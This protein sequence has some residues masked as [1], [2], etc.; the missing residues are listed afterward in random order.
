MKFMEFG[1]SN[2]VPLTA[3][4]V[5][6]LIGLTC[7]SIPILFKLTKRNRQFFSIANAF[8]GGVFL[9]AA[10]LHM[11]P[12]AAEGFNDLN[13]GGY[14]WANLISACGFCCTLFLE[15]VL[16]PGH[17]ADILLGGG[18]QQN[19]ESEKKKAI[20][21]SRT[22][23][24]GEKPNNPVYT[25]ATPNSSPLMFPVPSASHKVHKCHNMSP[26]DRHCSRE[27]SPTLP[28]IQQISPF[29]AIRVQNNVRNG[30][31]GSAMS[32]PLLPENGYASFS[33]NGKSA[34][35]VSSILKL[36]LDRTPR[37]RPVP[38]VTNSK[39]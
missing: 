20:D 10:M 2:V 5:L 33:V 9:G 4:P 28:I 1:R 17:E 39:V 34:H 30:S 18:H 3:I 12:D 36:D 8:S 31:S 19:S 29:K 24:R 25:I 16:S 14:P 26:V 13:E 7:G 15:L 27:E 21:D 23:K 32:S 35:S 6:F 37:K 38:L 11:L 22:Q